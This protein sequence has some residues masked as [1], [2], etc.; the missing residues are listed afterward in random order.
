L[1]LKKLSVLTLLA[2]VLETIAARKGLL[3]ALLGYG[4]RGARLRSMEN[5]VAVNRLW[6]LPQELKGL[7]LS[8]LASKELFLYVQLLANGYISIR[9]WF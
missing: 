7:V 6:Q 2:A 8:F 3:L 9:V 4:S 5:D 1:F